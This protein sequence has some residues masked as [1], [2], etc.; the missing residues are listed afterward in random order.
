MWYVIGIVVGI[1]YLAIGFFIGSFSAALSG[2]PRASM[3]FLTGLLFWP[4]LVFDGIRS[5]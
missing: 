1:V 2:G 5:K 4:K 3:A